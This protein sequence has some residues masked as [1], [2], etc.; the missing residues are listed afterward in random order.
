MTVNIFNETQCELGECPLWHPLRNELFWVDIVGKTL[1]SCDDVIT[2]SWK[3]SEQISATGWVDEYRLLVASETALLLFNIET[4]KSA[5]LQPLEADNSTTRSND[6]RADPWG[7]FWIGTMGKKAEPEAGSIYRYYQG[8]LR[9]LYPRITTPNAICFSP[10]K[11]FAYFA[12]TAQSKIWRQHLGKEDGWPQDDPKVFIDLSASGIKPDGAVCDSE[13]YLWN[14]QYG[15]SRLAR[16]SPD[17]VLV[18]EIAL[19]TENI[20]CPAFGSSGRNSL[21]ITSALEGLAK[22]QVKKQIHAGKTF[23]CDI[24]VSGQAENRISIP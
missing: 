22:E 10:D 8:E 11:Q 19:P 21:F 13:G 3:F 1:Y 16:Y 2:R 20:T 24:G 9:L 23:V 15:A 17:G 7:G 18:Q 5:I 6:G 12:D 14:A 4:G